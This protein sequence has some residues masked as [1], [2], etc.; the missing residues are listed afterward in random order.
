MAQ[1]TAAWEKDSSRKADIEKLT[2][3][4]SRTKF[5]VAGLIVLS[6]ALYLIVTGTLSGARY[7]ITVDDLLADV[8]GEF[9]G[10]TVRI[11]GAVLGDTIVYDTSDPGMPVLEF[12]ISHIPSEFDNLALA[13]HESVNNPDL[14]RVHVRIEN[15]AMPDLLQ[16]EAQAIVTGTLGEDGVFH[17]NELL[18]KCPSRFEEAGV[19]QAIAG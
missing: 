16:H 2:K 19:D 3:R 15:E 9:A 13:L 7:F 18:L 8:D 4:G 10:E 5:M 14:A 11:S 17:A 6:A 12:T 1:M